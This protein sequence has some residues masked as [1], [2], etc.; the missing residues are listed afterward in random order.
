MH[1]TETPIIRAL[2]YYKDDE[3]IRFHMP[4]HKGKPLDNPINFLL[5]NEVFAADVTNIP[6]MDDLHQPHGVIQEAQQLAAEAFGADDTYFLINGSS[7]GLQAIILTACNPG[8]KILVPRNAHRSVLSGIILSGAVPI[9]YLPEYS[10]EYGFF[11]ATNPQ[12][13]QENLAKHPDIRAVLV[14]Y[15]TYQGIASDIAAVSDIC[16]A[17]G[18]LLLVDEAH[19]PHLK[20]HDNLPAS[21]LDLGA[22]AVVHGSHKL[23]T[24][25]TQA[26]MLHVKGER[27]NRQ[28]L[29]FVL[30]LLQSTSTSYLLLASL[31]GARCVFATRGK[32]RIDKALQIS[33]ILRHKLEGLHGIR[34]FD[35]E[36]A[37]SWPAVTGLDTT[38]VTISMRDCNITGFKTEEI[39][40]KQFGIQVELADLYTILLLVTA[41]NTEQEAET[42]VSALDE[43]ITQNRQEYRAL[44]DLCPKTKTFLPEVVMSPRSAISRSSRPVSLEQASGHICA[45]TIACYPPGIPVICPGERITVEVIDYLSSMRKKGGRFQGCADSTLASIIVIR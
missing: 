41:S 4:G 18:I 37:R 31:D 33:T 10:F 12:V 5:G 38:K 42:V 1:Q 26:S 8:D 27:I 14:V 2:Q 3:I 22:D 44:R 29:S 34:T 28:K 36:I 35:S 9:F 32:E 25:F 11:T 7:C 13:I 6:G 39:L 15:P 20:F 24:A 45:E 19:G 30:K 23:L 43:L 17:A 40:R 21:S 16:H